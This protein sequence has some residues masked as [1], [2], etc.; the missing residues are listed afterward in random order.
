[1]D[2]IVA[3]GEIEQSLVDANRELIERFDKKIQAT[4][5]RVRGG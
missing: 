5:G 1:M 2:N 4:I 3:E